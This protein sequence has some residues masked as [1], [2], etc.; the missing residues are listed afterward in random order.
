M[1][2]LVVILALILLVLHQ[3]FW[4]WGNES[5]VL[6]F[7]PMGLAYHAAYSIACALMGALAI[8]YLWTKD[9]SDSE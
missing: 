5:L 9:K 4:L 6:G 7:M 1:K 3:D 8:K 2:V